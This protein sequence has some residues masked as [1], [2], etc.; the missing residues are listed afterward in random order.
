[1]YLVHRFDHTG[2]NLVGVPGKTQLLM[3]LN[4]IIN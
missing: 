1:V 2:M 3:A 4:Y